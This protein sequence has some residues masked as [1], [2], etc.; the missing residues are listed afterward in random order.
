VQGRTAAPAA[1]SP[2]LELHLFIA[3]LSS[4]PA[5]GFLGL[6]PKLLSGVSRKWLELQL[7]SS[8]LRTHLFMTI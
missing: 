5:S 1:Q 7:E 8:L 3:A 6:K 2:F 4:S